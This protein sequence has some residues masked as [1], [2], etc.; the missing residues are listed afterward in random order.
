MTTAFDVANHIITLAEKMGEAVTNM[1]L[2]KLLYYSYAWHLAQFDTRL[3]SENIQAWQYGPVVPVVYF[4]Y[5]SY[6]ADNIK[7]PED[8]NT[9]NIST[10]S[11]DL[12]EEV[13]SVYGN[14]SA[15]EL[16]RLSHSESPWR[17]VYEDGKMNAIPD[18]LISSFF[19][20]KQQADA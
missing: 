9:D 17:D 19:K 1:K 8:G 14:K 7:S 18:E 3:F 4:K 5:N 16:V 2:Q 13:F 6:G 11:K 12:I 15:I 20:K 10:E